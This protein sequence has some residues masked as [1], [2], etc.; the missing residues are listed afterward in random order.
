MPKALPG[1]FRRDGVVP[2]VTKEESTEL[3]EAKRRIRFAGVGSGGDA[4]GSCLPFPRCQPKMMFPLVL[5]LAAPQAPVRVTV[6]VTCLGLG[7][8]PPSLLP[9]VC[10]PCQ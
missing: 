5:E 10:Q 9:M 2:G 8:L 7:V 1:E 3:R 6:A 4:P